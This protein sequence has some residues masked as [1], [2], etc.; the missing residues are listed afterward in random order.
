[1]PDPVDYE[2]MR[3]RV[4]NMWSGFNGT[5]YSSAEI[6]KEL[7]VTRNVV[8]GIVS[9]ARANGDPRAVVKGP[10]PRPRPDRRPARNAP[11]PFVPPAIH[12]KSVSESDSVR[13]LSDDLTED[14]PLYPTLSAAFCFSTNNKAKTVL[15]IGYYECHYP[16]ESVTN[17]GFRMYCGRDARDT[18][19]AH[20]KA[21]C[22]EHYKR[23]FYKKEKTL[24]RGR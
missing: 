24:R 22:N 2:N 18:V 11:P 23:M 15:N 19:R 9:R 16:L 8:I 17:D 5:A 10:P 12:N 1:M 3:G 7:G 14:G 4:L 6:G 21:Y 13:D 20:Q